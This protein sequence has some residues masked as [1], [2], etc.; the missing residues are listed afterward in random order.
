MSV[1]LRSMVNPE[2]CNFLIK[3]L[4][5]MGILIVY[6]KVLFIFMEERVGFGVRSSALLLTD[7]R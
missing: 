2:K 6:I 4:L 7:S 1:V 3:I 5:T